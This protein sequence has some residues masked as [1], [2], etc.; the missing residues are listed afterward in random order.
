MIKRRKGGSFAERLAKPLSEFY[1]CLNVMC[2]ELAEHEKVLPAGYVD[3]FRTSLH[4]LNGSLL[5]IIKE[6]E[7]HAIE[8]KKELPPQG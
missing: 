1:D 8:Q 7:Q 3:K 6:M 2:A 5:V 4:N